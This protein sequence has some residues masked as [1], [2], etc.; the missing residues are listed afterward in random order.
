MKV[1]HKETKAPHKEM[2]ARTSYR[3]V[4]Q[5]EGPP[6]RLESKQ[7]DDPSACQRL[8]RR[9]VHSATKCRFFRKAPGGRSSRWEA[10]LSL[11]EIDESA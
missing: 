2:K 1:Q 11:D 9:S 3:L 7:P 4:L 8:Y 5:V 10:V 6:S